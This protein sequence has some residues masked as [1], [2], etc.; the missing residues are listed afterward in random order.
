[1]GQVQVS[2]RGGTVPTS[3][4]RKLASLARQAVDR[5]V[6]V[7]FMNIGQPDIPTPQGMLDAYRHF[8]EAVLAYAPSDG[9]VSYREKLAAY[10]NDL[11]ASPSVT[12]DDIV[13][14]VGGSEA[15]LFALAA[16]TDPGD[17]V[18]VCE[19]Y[20]TNYAGFVHMLSLD[21]DA[22]S[23]RPEESYHISPE[24]VEAAI[25][26]KTRALIIPSPGNPTGVVLSEDELDALIDICRRH[27]IFFICDEVYREF[28]YDQPIGTRAPSVLSRVDTDNIT[29]VVDS[30][31]KRYSACGARV[32]CLVTRNREVR[33]AA[34]R[35]GQAR[36]SPATVDQ[37]AAMAALDTPDTYFQEVVK[38]YQSRRDTLVSGLA[39]FGIQ[40]E[41][42][43]GAFYLAVALPVEDATAFSEWMVSEFTLNGET[44]CVTPLEG[45]YQTPGRGK[46]EIRMA[47][48]LNEATLKR[49]TEIL[50]AALREWKARNI[51]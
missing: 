38:E 23:T 14:T 36:L 2:R 50:G 18:L 16:V 39:A 6:K 24:R 15:I 17:R 26:Q 1:M 11:P 30:V 27:G 13:V 48:V 49:C 31:S 20:Y 32:G 47:Y 21:I 3:P 34:L 12:A 19:P 9:F 10:Y 29:I 28:V 42:P 46:N 43:K 7:H 25:T 35:F 44:V 5:G 37:Y 4:I 40:V 8:D 41:K 45:F 33:D 51:T 22:V